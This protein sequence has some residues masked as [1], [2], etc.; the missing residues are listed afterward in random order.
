MSGGPLKYV[1]IAD[2]VL[3][4]GGENGGQYPFSNSVLIDDEVEVLIDTGMG[5]NSAARVAEEKRIDLVLNS[6]GHRDHTA[7]NHLFKDAEICSHKLDALAI[8]SRGSRVD[9][10]FED[11]HVFDLGSVEL[12]VVHTPGHSAGHCCFSIPSEGFVFLS[13]IDL[14]P[15]GPW[16]GGS[17]SDIDQFIRS[18]RRIRKIGFEVAVSSHRGIVRGRETIGGRLDGYLNKIFEREKRL[19]EFLGKERTLDEIVG[20]S[21]IYGKSPE[22]KAVYERFEKIMIEKHLERL[23]R[24]DLVERGDGGFRI[25]KDFG[26]WHKSF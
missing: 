20:Q 21:I 13:D 10:E 23:I 7:C 4:I 9:F 14:S 17:D 6:H 8:R 12:E 22:P 2:S 26:K 15:F 19:M 24:G 18:I 16:Y 25:Q 3:F 1:E 11:G 5:P